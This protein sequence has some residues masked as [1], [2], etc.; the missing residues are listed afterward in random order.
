MEAAIQGAT[1]SRV[2]NGKLSSGSYRLIDYSGTLWG[3]QGNFTLS[4]TGGGTTR[5]SFSTVHP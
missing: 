5:Q 4:G 1:V 2:L 3:D